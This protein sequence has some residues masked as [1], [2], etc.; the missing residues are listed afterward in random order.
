MGIAAPNAEAPKMEI[1]APEQMNQG[2]KGKNIH[3]FEARKKML[4][5]TLEGKP[6]K[7]QDKIDDIIKNRA[8]ADTNITNIEV[9]PNLKYVTFIYKNMYKIKYEPKP[10]EG[11][12]GSDN[13]SFIDTTTGKTYEMQIGLSLFMKNL[14]PKYRKPEQHQKQLS[15]RL[16][17]LS[18]I[19]EIIQ[20]KVKSDST[21]IFNNDEP[22]I[23]KGDKIYFATEKKILKKDKEEFE[24]CF[25]KIIY[26]KTRKDGE[27]VI[28][29]KI[30][31]E[32]MKSDRYFENAYI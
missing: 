19:F 27:T 5:E 2:E 24:E 1:Q 7:N 28:P 17:Y 3:F 20:E 10:K 25:R 16:E 8:E 18:K 15:E 4:E 11:D 22:I 23:I 12:P 30:T 32:E 31:I 29:E 21:L 13:I 6:L 9:N 14:E 26:Q